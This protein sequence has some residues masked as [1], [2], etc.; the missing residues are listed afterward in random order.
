MSTLNSYFSGVAA[1]YLS[2]VDTSPSKS[3]QHEIGS[4]KFEAIL[5]VP[6]DSNSKFEADFLY[7]DADKDEVIRSTGLLT[8]YDSRKNNP[9]RSPEYRL[10]YPNN[11]VTESFKEGDFCL[12]GKLL[13]GKLLIAIAPR[14]TPEEFRL[15]HLFGLDQP[16]D[17]W[18]VEGAVKDSK[19][20]LASRQI[21]EVI[22]I[23]IEI[24]SD[25]DLDKLLAKFGKFFPS[26][27][28]FS[29]YAR[30]TC[31]HQLSAL[32]DPDETLA[33]WMAYEEDL[34][35][36][37]ERVIVKEKLVE[38]FVEV[39]EFISFSLSV[40]NRRKSRVG[41]ALENHLSALFDLNA[42]RYERGV[43]TENNAKPD[44]IFPSSEEYHNPAFKSP[45]LKMLGAKT[46]CKDRWRQV[47]S[48][49]AKIPH[50]HLFT[51]ETA[52]SLNQLLEMHSFSLTVVSTP[53]VLATYPLASKG[54]TMSLQDFINEVR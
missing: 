14:E 20:T 5:G 30:Q 6:S 15:R 27:K 7:F 2:A 52:L 50:K 39:D 32:D 16:T 47:L 13:S 19:L 17:H 40:Q 29:E 1:K 24:T 36:A 9:N 23:E 35:R 3:N 44:F 38:G 4:N 51:L 12:I 37:M 31:P 53:D 48:E 33:E 28:I 18:V 42:I 43:R 25:I 8:W 46:T 45:P 11:T 49:A 54:W 22:G 10:Y 21:L 41:H 26:T 34:F